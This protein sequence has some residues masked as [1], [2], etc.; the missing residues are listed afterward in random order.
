MNLSKRYLSLWET[1]IFEE[2]SLVVGCGWLNIPARKQVSLEYCMLSTILWCRVPC[3]R[4]FDGNGNVPQRG[5]WQVLFAGMLPVKENEIFVLPPYMLFR[6]RHQPAIIKKYLADKDSY[7]TSIRGGI[8]LKQS[9]VSSIYSN[10]TAHERTHHSF[11]CLFH[12]SFLPSFYISSL[13]IGSF[14]SY[15]LL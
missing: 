10:K 4:R 12:L 5:R 8:L 3:N 13:C 9:T 6:Q 1:Y 14:F 11:V 7:P 2:G 15:T